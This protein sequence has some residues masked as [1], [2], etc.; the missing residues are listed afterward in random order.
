MSTLAEIE[1]AITRLPES[2]V[3]QLTVWLQM[4]KRPQASSLARPREPDF[5]QRARRIWGDRPPGETL[6][7]LLSRSRD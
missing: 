6:S 1:Q 2:Q 4:R 3:Q 7:A 5:V